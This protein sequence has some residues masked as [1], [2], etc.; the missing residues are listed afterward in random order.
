MSHDVADHRVRV[1]A[2][3]VQIESGS[4]FA[5]RQSP[6]FLSRQADHRRLTDEA[7]IEHHLRDADWIQV[8]IQEQAESVVI[9]P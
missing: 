2:L 4:S 9:T 7:A 5:T 6:Y 1:A 8:L 3:G